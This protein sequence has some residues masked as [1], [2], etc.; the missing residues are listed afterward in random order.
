[1]FNFTANQA[2]MQFGEMMTLEQLRTKL[3]HSVEQARTGAVHDGEAVFD[4]MLQDI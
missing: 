4:E 1:M 2:K 3:A